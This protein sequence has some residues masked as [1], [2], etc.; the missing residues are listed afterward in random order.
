MCKYK[1]GNPKRA[2]QFLC[3]HCM[4]INQ[5]SGIQRGGHQREKYHI[6]DLMCINDNCRDLPYTKNIEIR[7]CD[8]YEDVYEKALKLRINYYNE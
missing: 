1:N 7:H 6:K 5:L 8:S 2:S 3:L 4:N